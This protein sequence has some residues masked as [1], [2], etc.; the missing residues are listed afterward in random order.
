MARFLPTSL[1]Q[2]ILIV[3]LLG[4]SLLC[5]F[6]IPLWHAW[7]SEIEVGWTR[8]LRADA[9]RMRRD[10]VDH[11]V[12]KLVGVIGDRVGE[13]IDDSRM[14]I[15]LDGP[16]GRRLAGNLSYAPPP[17]PPGGY[18]RM[19]VQAPAG[20]V[21]IHLLKT[22]LPGGYTL[23]VGR[24]ITRFVHLESMFVR[25]MVGSALIALL[26]AGLTTAVAQH[27]M[28]R[29]ISGISRAAS[30][31]ME[32][33]LARRLPLSARDDDV[34]R[35]TKTVN[36]M[37]GQ[38][39]YLVDNVR[40]SSNAIAHDLRTPL[41]ELRAHLEHLAAGR[42]RHGDIQDGLE[43]AIG[44][45]DRVIDIFNAILRLAEIDSGVR[46]AGFREFDVAPVLAEAIE[47]CEPLIEEA[48]IALVR[49]IAAD[50]AVRGDP[51]LLAQVLANLIDNAVKYAGGTV[52]AGIAIDCVRA[53]DGW[54]RM[55]V[56]DNGPGIAAADH[57]KVLQP[58]FRADASRASPGIGL[59]LTL[60]AAV[61]RLHGGTLELL[62]NAPGLRVV[63]RFPP[64]D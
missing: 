20:P 22:V 54:V 48:G 17:A 34:D 1:R 36:R 49:R 26:A 11:G 60:V 56:A 45:V 62:D 47:F 35:L 30:D 59:G 64:L 21:T 8:M 3:M 50:V 9:D 10:L 53:P 58:F 28:N 16:D 39:E 57:R 40:Q 41:A 52:G 33:N 13:G 6:C 43:I 38:L 4:A 37:L 31:I 12:D 18:A 7:N 63:L 44:D 32:G 55:S 24:D 61:T 19:T 42:L 46:R 5:T 2:Q 27:S 25:G 14:V 23:W 29:R 15:L 51:V